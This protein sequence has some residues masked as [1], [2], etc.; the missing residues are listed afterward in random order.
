MRSFGTEISRNRRPKSDLSPEAWVAIIYGLENQQSLTILA[1]QFHCSQFTI[2]WTKNTYK[3][4]KTLQNWKW[5][6]CLMKL[7]HAE[8]HYIYL[9]VHQKSNMTWNGLVSNTILEV[10]RSTIQH[11]MR[12]F[13][14]KKMEKQAA[15][16]FK[17]GRCQ[18]IAW[19]CK[20]VA[21]FY[22]M[23]RCHLLW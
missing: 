19:I 6:G 14:L 7:S 18:K 17:K 21:E 1:K 5:T 8:Q 22:R 23:E 13:S 10:S 12:W 16:P 11:V 9:L 2:Y 20:V 15:D 4:T 3:S